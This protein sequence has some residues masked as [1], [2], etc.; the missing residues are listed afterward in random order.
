MS[1]GT[2]ADQRSIDDPK[3]QA[4][5]ERAERI[6]GGGLR[7]R[8][9]PMSELKFSERAARRA[10]AIAAGFN[11]MEKALATALEQRFTIDPNETVDD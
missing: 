6:L 9:K 1:Y 2:S 7:G 3:E 5:R 10:D 11:S 8:I 4:R